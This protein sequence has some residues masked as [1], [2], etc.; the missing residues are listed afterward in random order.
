MTALPLAG[1]RV[2]ELAHLIAGPAC[3]M[4]LADMGADVVK[5]EQPGAGDASRSAYGSQLGGESAVFVT[6]NRNKRSVALDLARPEGRATFERLVAHAAR[7]RERRPVAR[8]R[9]KDRGARRLDGE[10]GAHGSLGSPRMRS[11]MMFLWMFGVPPPI[12]TSGHESAMRCHFPCS[13]AASLRIVS[14]RS[15]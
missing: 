9:R 13:G 3:G 5:I 2:L 15:T 12:T 10:R 6:V 4:Y 11:A 1:Y 14:S 7:E 8:S